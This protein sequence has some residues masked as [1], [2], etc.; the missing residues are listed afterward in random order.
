LIIV[1]SPI[2][3]AHDSSGTCCGAIENEGHHVGQTLTRSWDRLSATLTLCWAVQSSRVRERPYELR[4]TR[5]HAG[6]AADARGS[7]GDRRANELLEL[8]GIHR[9][10]RREGCRT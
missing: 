4:N 8:G 2:K 6:D 1:S 7:F 3:L 10:C 5:A 9:G